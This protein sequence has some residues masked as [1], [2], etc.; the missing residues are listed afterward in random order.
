MIKAIIP[1]NGRDQILCDGPLCEHVETYRAHLDALGYKPA[2]IRWHLKLIPKFNRWLA[3]RGHALRDLDEEVIER[4]VESHRRKA[5]YQLGVRAVLR[6]FLDQLRKIGAVPSAV[7]SRRIQALERMIDEYRR[8]LLQERGL[9]CSSVDNY[10]RYVEQFLSE[11][12]GTGRA[13]LSRLRAMDLS[14]F[15]RREAQRLGHGHAKHAVVALR[16]YLRYAQF[17]GYIK[18]NLAAAVPMVAQ[19]AMDSLPKYLPSGVVQRVLDRCERTTAVGKRDYAI[20]LLL[21]RLGLRAG[22][23]SALR[24]ED[25]DWESGR[26]AVLCK[27]SGGSAHLPLPFDVG[28]AIALY[29]KEGR[30]RCSCRNVFV[31]AHAPHEPFSH[32]AV[33]SGLAKRA[34]NRAGVQ[35]GRKGAHLFRHT[36]ATEMLKNGASLGEIG[37]VL[38]H[39]DTNTTAIY[40]KVDVNALRELALPWP[41]GVQ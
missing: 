28:E 20:L 19:W 36:L 6:R 38:R 25:I 34:L 17:R 32:A 9:A 41:G 37:Q 39:K 21:A 11:R 12:F 30:P 1:A 24:L 18:V 23:V 26:I 15:V 13:D 27:K 5:P 4:F 29:L 8:F 40:A 2:T 35:S 7:K 10:S 33:V 14:A 16:S 22:E 3:R 31:R